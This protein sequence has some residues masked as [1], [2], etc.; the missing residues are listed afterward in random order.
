MRI[1]CFLLLASLITG[2]AGKEILKEPVKEITEDKSVE[3]VKEKTGT[4]PS[5]GWSDKDTYTVTVTAPDIDKAREAAKHKILHD[6]V[7]VRMMNE[8]RFTD[9][10]KISAEFDKPLKDGKVISQKQI[11]GG[12]QIYFQIRDNGL[13]E[14]F[15]RK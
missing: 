8:S 13:K 5:I 10:T 7:K 3:V 12:L 14:K 1:I 6:I 9:I 11:G 4:V 2:C 15:E